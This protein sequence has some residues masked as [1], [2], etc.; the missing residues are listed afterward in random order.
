MERRPDGASEAPRTTFGRTC[1][2]D[3]KTTSWPK[4]VWGTWSALVC[5]YRQSSCLEKQ[6]NWSGHRR[7]RPSVYAR[8]YTRSGILTC[9][10]WTAGAQM[11]PQPPG[12]EPE[13]CVPKSWCAATRPGF[14]E[15]SERWTG[16]VS[17]RVHNPNSDT[18]SLLV[19]NRDP[20]PVCFRDVCTPRRSAPSSA[21]ADECGCE[22][23]ARNRS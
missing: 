4:V 23:L 18:A 3:P 11:H 8:Q 13:C 20:Q 9:I 2:S 1:R 7:D 15:R 16:S 6:P 14:P 17:C 22:F 10:R 5:C 12:P 19:K 21:A